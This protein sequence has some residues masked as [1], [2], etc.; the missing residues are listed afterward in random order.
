MKINAIPSIG[1]FEP[2]Q[3]IRPGGGAQKMVGSFRQLLEDSINQ[4]NDLQAQADVLAQDLATGKAD[5]L[6]EVMLALNKASLA[7][8]FTLQV[9]NK[10]IE[11]YQE[12]MRTQA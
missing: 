8:E 3:A 12:I 9:R 11:A 2:S 10:V 6:H 7:L 4:V 5:N 1:P